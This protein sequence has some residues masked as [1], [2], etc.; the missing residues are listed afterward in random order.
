MQLSR[1]G[2]CLWTGGPV[3]GV[4]AMLRRSK[5]STPNLPETPVLGQQKPE[6]NRNVNF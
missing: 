5:V 1:L 6:C 3:S 4:T 2:R